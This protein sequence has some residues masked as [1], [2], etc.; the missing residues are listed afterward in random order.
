MIVKI[1]WPKYVDDNLKH[2]IEFS[3]KSN[4]SLAVNKIKN[5]IE[6]LLSKYKH[7]NN[8]LNSSQRLDLRSSNKHIALQNSH[9]ERYTKTV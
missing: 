8:I 4:I 3:I 7:G 6:E 5:K 1:D 9:V 2:E